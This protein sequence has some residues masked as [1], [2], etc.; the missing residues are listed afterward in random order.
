M[1]AEPRHWFAVDT[2][3]AGIGQAMVRAFTAA[4]YAVV[5]IDSMPQPPQLICHLQYPP[6]PPNVL[7]LPAGADALF[8]RIR[9]HFGGHGLAALINN[10]V[11]QILDELA[12]LAL[13]LA[14]WRI[15]FLNGS[16]VALDGGTGSVLHDSA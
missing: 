3:A 10:A 6:R 7:D 16:C 13:A 5:A 1:T 2:G 4:G 11:A 15:G 9:D 12:Q 14:E 8:A